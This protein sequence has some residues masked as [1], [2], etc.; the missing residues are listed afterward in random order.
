MDELPCVMRLDR[1]SCVSSLLQRVDTKSHLI[2]PDLI[3]IRV[4]QMDASV[5]N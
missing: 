4:L 3:Q 2:Q 1:V 5:S